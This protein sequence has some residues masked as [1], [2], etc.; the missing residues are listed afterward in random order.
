MHVSFN[1]IKHHI[2]KII[3]EADILGSGDSGRIDPTNS[4]SDPT[5]RNSDPT[6]SE[7]TSDE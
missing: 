7:Q 3:E 5:S 2:L 6:S 1:E 4:I